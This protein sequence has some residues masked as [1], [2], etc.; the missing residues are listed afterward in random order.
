MQTRA[1]RADD[2]PE[3]DRLMSGFIGWMGSDFMAERFA[4]VTAPRLRLVAESDGRI[5]G[6]GH[7]LAAPVVRGARASGVLFVAPDARGQGVGSALWEQL[8]ALVRQAG[9]GGLLV[10]ADHEDQP[11]LDLAARHGLVDDGLHLESALDLEVGL[12]ATDIAVRTVPLDDPA[13]RDSVYELLLELAQDAPDVGP[14]QALMPRTVFDT[15]FPESWQ[16]LLLLSGDD[17]AGLIIGF[18]R[19]TPGEA[20]I[21]FIGIR[22]AW[23]GRGWSPDL[24]AV[25]AEMLRARGFTRLVTQNMGHNHAILAAN[26]RVG[27]TV[28]G[29]YRDLV[30]DFA[31]AQ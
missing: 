2:G 19:P 21:A 7:V 6:Y 8:T 28:T 4:K 1:V 5:V 25:Y 29:G 31:S 3:L 22:P 18:P 10:V 23:R 12:P 17:V 27:F 24:M 20:N 14:G 11:T 26:A 15:M 13:G 16:G 9:V 30:H